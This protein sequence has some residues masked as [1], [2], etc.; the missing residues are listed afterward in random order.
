M[1]FNFILI[2]CLDEGY[3]EDVGIEQEHVWGG[4]VI[5]SYAFR[6]TKGLCRATINQLGIL[7]WSD[8][9]HDPIHQSMTEVH[10]M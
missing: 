8:T 4:R 1:L 2:L 5:L 6:W 7:D 10:R 9:F 3:K